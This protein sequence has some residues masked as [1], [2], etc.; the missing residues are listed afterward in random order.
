MVKLVATKQGLFYR[1]ALNLCEVLIVLPY[2]PKF[3]QSLHKICFHHR[4]TESSNMDN[5]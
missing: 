2:C 1:T 3:F 4:F 5:G